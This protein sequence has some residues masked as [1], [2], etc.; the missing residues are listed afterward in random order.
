MNTKLTRGVGLA[1]ISAFF[2]ALMSALTKAL[3]A[4]ADVPTQIII[5]TRFF[6]SALTLLPW[7]SHERIIKKANPFQTQRLGLH[8]FRS[9]M[10]MFALSLFYFSLKYLPLVDGVLLMSTFP[11]FVPIVALISKGIKTSWQL[12]AGMAT[13]FIGIL[14]V[15]Q[16]GS[17][18]FQIVSLLPLAAAVGGAINIFYVRQLGKTE[19]NLTI[20]SYYFCLATLLSGIFSIGSWR[21][22]DSHELLLLISIGIVASMY[23]IALTQALKD[24]PARIIAPLYYLAIPFSL[25]FQWFYWHLLPDTW[26]IIGI[27]IVC[28]SAVYVVLYGNRKQ[29]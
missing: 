7:L 24:A 27:S 25:L 29:S 23:Q 11:F 15:L 16:P 14:L 9:C 6:I 28:L 22:I 21:S 26:S 20:L 10:A 19:S 12:W 17:E 4:D 2:F 18:V 8:I 3:R 1:I 5:F 13:G